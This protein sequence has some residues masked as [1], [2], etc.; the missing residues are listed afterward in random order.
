[1]SLMKG[2]LQTVGQSVSVWWKW[3][4]HSLQ[5]TKIKWKYHMWKICRI[6]NIDSFIE[7]TSPKSSDAKII[8]SD[9]KVI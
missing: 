9:L 6:Q 5:C 7:V 8:W 3:N 2:T 1:M 4:T